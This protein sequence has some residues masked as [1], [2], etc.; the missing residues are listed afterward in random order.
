M[1]FSD[2]Q[3]FFPKILFFD[4]FTAIFRSKLCRVNVIFGPLTLQ[5]KSIGALEN[6]Q[7][8]LKMHMND[9][10]HILLQTEF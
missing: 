6:A 5:E 4:R 9:L 2:S 1:V 8:V 7:I 3:I 10:G